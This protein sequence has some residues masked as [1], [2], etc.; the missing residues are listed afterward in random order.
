[1]KRLTGDAAERYRASL[2]AVQAVLDAAERQRRRERLGLAEAAR[3]QAP[4]PPAELLA[5]LLAE[6]PEPPPGGIM[7]GRW[8]AGE[9]QPNPGPGMWAS[10]E[11]VA[12]A[13]HDPAP[14]SAE[15][16]ERAFAS[17]PDRR[18]R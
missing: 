16:D 18:A 10:G 15:P 14:G 3:E 8:D 12:A 9:V 2:R 17:F 13:E 11:R 1:V 4:E 5:D 6:L 7:A